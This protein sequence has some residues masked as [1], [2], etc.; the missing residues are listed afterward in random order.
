MKATL[1][2]Q[3][4][5]GLT[6]AIPAPDPFPD[7]LHARQVSTST[8]CSPTTQLCYNEYTTAGNSIF[9]IAISESATG[10][11]FDIAL[12]L[13]APAGQGW[14]G[15]SFGGSMTEAPLAVA[16]P[17]GQSVTASSRWAR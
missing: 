15:F 17:N 8:Y 10:S 11:D 14:V 4:L 6:A 1:A 12:Q 3:A 13:V 7:A 5:I 9:R 16:W 2:I